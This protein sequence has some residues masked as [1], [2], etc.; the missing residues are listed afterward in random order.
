MNTLRNTTVKGHT[1]QGVWD[2]VDLPPRKKAIKSQLIFKLKLGKDNQPVL[3]K[4]RLVA[5]GFQ[6]LWGV[7]YVDSFSATAHQSAIRMMLVL[8]AQKGWYTNNTD[9]QLAVNAPIEETMYIE[10]P[11]GVETGENAGK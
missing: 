6:Q 7:D 1:K 8:V 10:P 11:E 9:I 2:V 5:K 4:V 3:Y